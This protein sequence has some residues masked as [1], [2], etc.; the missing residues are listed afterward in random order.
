VVVVTGSLAFGVHLLEQSSRTA[1]DVLN[2]RI[3]VDTINLNPCGDLFGD[4]VKSWSTSGKLVLKMGDAPELPINRRLDIF[5]PSGEE[6]EIALPVKMVSGKVN[7]R[8]M[9]G[10]IGPISGRFF[11]RV[12]NQMLPFEKLGWGKSTL[13]SWFWSDSTVRMSKASGDE[14]IVL[15]VSGRGHFFLAYAIAK[16]IASP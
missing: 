8:A 3:H 4:C 15:K 16:E 13:T 7:L 5:N 9:Y 1:T 2:P 11:F 10:R 12:G 6:G 14:S